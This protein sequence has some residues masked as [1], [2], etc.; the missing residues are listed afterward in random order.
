MAYDTY[1]NIKTEVLARIGIDDSDVDDVVDRALND[2]LQE[3]CQAHNFSWLYAKSSFITAAAYDTGAATVTEGSATVDG[4][5]A[6]FT[7][8]MVGRKF[9]CDDQTYTISAV[10]TSPAM[11]LTLSTNYAGTTGTNDY[12]IFQDEYSLASDVEDVLSM[13]QETNPY[14]LQKVG[15]EVMD[16]YWPQRSS[17]GYPVKYSIV[18]YDS[19]GYLKVALYPIPNYA[20]NIYYRYRKRVT[21]MSATTDTPIIPLR[22]RYV[23]AKGAL[24]IA[25]K[26]LDLPDIGGDYER[27]YRQGIAQLISADRKIDERLV[28]GSGADHELELVVLENWE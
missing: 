28:K 16:N 15:I 7:S 6:T 5:G 14:K 13:W 26:Y 24:Y 17:F 23:L 2:V 25:A 4:V 27:E 20:K 8:A 11:Q 18:G 3:I 9:F 10:T 19:S 1:A 21:E 12:I 22:Y